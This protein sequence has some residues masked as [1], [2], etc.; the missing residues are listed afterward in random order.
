MRRISLLLIILCAIAN[1]SFSQGEIPVDMYTGQPS[2]TIPIWT[3]NSGD[4]SQPIV[5]SYNAS[6]IHAESSFG[7]GWSIPTGSITRE[8]RSY[9]DD[10]GYNHPENLPTLGWLYI[11]SGDTISA[12][13]R[14][15]NPAA[16]GSANWD[17]GE[18][19]DHDTISEL[20]YEV[21]TEPDIFHYSTGNISGSF[22]FDNAWSIRTIP[23]ADVLITPT[24][25]SS[26]DR[27]ITSFTI[28]TNDGYVYTFAHLLSATRSATPGMY[29]NRQY[30]M[31]T[32]YELYNPSV[33]Y[34]R[35]WKLTRIDS[36]NGAY[37]TLSYSNI[38][39][40]STSQAEI[41]LYQ[42]PDP[43]YA[44][45]S[46]IIRNTAY[47]IHESSARAN[48]TAVTGS[49]GS[50]AELSYSGGLL[51]AIH[52]SDDRRG[53][54]TGERK[55]KSFNLGYLPVT[56]IFD[57]YANFP[58]K[59]V[60]FLKSL[61][62][63]S[64]CE[65][66]PPHQFDYNGLFVLTGMYYKPGT[67][68]RSST[69]SDQWGYANRV[70]NKY[71]F[72]K[73][74]IY[75]DEPMI[76][77]YRTSPIEDT[78]TEVI[79][80]GA[81]RSA[82]GDVQ[83]CLRSITTPEGGVTE[84]QFESNQ[85]LDPRT[86][87][88][89][90][91]GG[92]RVKRIS[93]HDGFNQTPIVKTFDYVDP[94]TGLSS[95]RLIRKPALAVPALTWKSPSGESFDKSF[96]SF[97]EEDVEK[98]QYLLVRREGDLTPGETT[99]GNTVGYQVVTVNRPGAGY[100][101]FEF[102][103][104]AAHGDAATGDWAP[105]V[106]KFARSSTSSSVSMG[107]VD[108]ANTWGFPFTPN[109]NYDYMRGLVARKSDYTSSGKLVQEAVTTYQ[110]LYASGTTPHKV[111]G[112]TYD[113]YPGSNPSDKIFFYGKYYLNTEAV[114]VPAKEVTTYY[115]ALDVADTI[116]RTD[117]VEYVYGSATHK[118][119][120]QVRRY[121]S[122]G[123]LY[124][125]HLKYPKDYTTHA[126]GANDAVAIHTMKSNNRHAFPIE[127]I[128]TLRKAGN[129]S[130]WVIGGSVVKLDPF[131]GSNIKVRSVWSLKVSPPV[132]WNDFTPSTI[133]N[134][135]EYKFRIDPRYEQLDSILQYTA[136]GAVR[137]S[138]NP[139]SRKKSSTGYSYGSSLATVQYSGALGTA[140]F[141]DFESTIPGFS[142]SSTT[143]YYGTGRTGRHAFYPGV[144][145][146]DTLTKA[147]VS[148]YIL[149]FWIK[150]DDA[151]DFT[152]ELKHENGTSLSP[153]ATT[154]FTAGHTNGT[155]FKYVQ[156][157]IPI[158]GHVPST[159]R[160]ELKAPNIASTPTGGSAPGLMPVI[161]D[162]FFYPE[163][164][165]MVSS[166]LQI[167][168]GVTS[169]TSGM[170]ETSYTE[171]DKLGRPNLVYDKDKN[172]VKRNVF[173]YTAQSPLVADFSIAGLTLGE[174]T[175]FT[176]AT[177]DCVTDAEYEWD[178]GSG[179]V[180]GTA[181]K[182]HTF[183]TLGLYTVSLRVTSVAYG[184]K[185]VTKSFTLVSTPFDIDICAKGAIYFIDGVPDLYALCSD[186]TKDPPGDGVIFRV[187]TLASVSTYQWQTRE[188][189]SATWVN[190]GG[191]GSTASQLT[192]KVMPDVT[193]S[194]YEVRCKITTTGGAIGYS[195]V[196]DV[197]FEN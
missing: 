1:H 12:T 149:S 150:S 97:D 9:P 55:V 141:S 169:V 71:P 123:N 43:F 61:T 127:T 57:S 73:L 8:V 103:V 144:T 111:W 4:I 20:N 145:L 56:Y 171:Y 11:H 59:T 102:L 15:F 17:A 44:N 121:T 99:H 165:D 154:S 193:Y 119:L 125:T 2:I 50:K 87:K 88:A 95:G 178:L 190:A 53:T 117:S 162:V 64:D 35:E 116:R 72:P 122:E 196:M 49:T 51:Q 3:V 175:T 63:H 128:Q 77:R 170:G 163:N 191:S 114:T 58:D 31:T 62:E 86:G 28:T 78:P 160:V 183:D 181:V 172:I 41:G 37:I 23:Y 83:G 29:A 36:P 65:S 79:V 66:L 19:T 187:S 140:S 110:T 195:P 38:S 108:A 179:F 152:V 60:Q 159:F 7:R 69:G 120:T 107:I 113:M 22:V 89:E 26:N 186:I 164:T 48:L 10:V 47:T 14:D 21:D 197:I 98:Y 130:V 174:T 100:A 134:A 136:S 167:P 148:H 91:A 68:L 129:D 112:L 192:V 188:L 185:T 147:N 74:Y 96:A 156:K 118:L 158:P 84:F 194:S 115:D 46:D 52:I 30:Y 90:T 54:T 18:E 25:T 168:Y 173:R 42:Y 85:Y 142:F 133:V 132:Y 166:T 27:R 40:S 76:D 81:N 6:A 131:G 104:P 13:I 135:G 176:A 45:P 137:S 33:S 109:P 182:T 24:Y 92:F 177:D 189:G 143:P 184:T 75:P 151:V 16:D 80:P 67:F 124:T 161:D 180:S 139:A 106:N 101:R 138:Y 126:T 82:T 39:N 70:A 153:A 5:L 94:V 155:A 34:T 146:M 93:Y 32:E 157:M 105:T